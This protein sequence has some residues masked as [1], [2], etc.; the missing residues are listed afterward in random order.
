MSPKTVLEKANAV[1]R[2]IKMRFF[3]LRT[4]INKNR[5][6]LA[7]LNSAFLEPFEPKINIETLLLGQAPPLAVLFKIH[8]DQI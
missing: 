6:P 3:M 8:H 5:T 4:R 2:R 1:M 7:T